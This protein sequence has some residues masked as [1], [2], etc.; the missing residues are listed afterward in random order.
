MMLCV[1]TE[2]VIN[3]QMWFCAG[4]LRWVN[5]MEWSGSQIFTKAPFI[6]FAVRGKEAGI[7]KTHGPLS[8]LKVRTHEWLY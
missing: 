7:L 1:Y 2:L 6:Q 3:L 4:N 8:F 5:S